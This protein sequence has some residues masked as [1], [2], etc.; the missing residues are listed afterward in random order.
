[1]SNQ[2]VDIRTGNKI[3]INDSVFGF[4][5]GDFR[6]KYADFLPIIQHYIQGGCFGHNLHKQELDA[7]REFI[8]NVSQL[9]ESTVDVLGSTNVVFSK[10]RSDEND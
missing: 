9:E 4:T 10:R 2:I 3:E 8:K 5:I 7:I 6:F 1:M